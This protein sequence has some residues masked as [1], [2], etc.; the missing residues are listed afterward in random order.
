MTFQTLCHRSSASKSC[1]GTTKLV[2]CVKTAGIALLY[3]VLFMSKKFN[4]AFIK[5]ELKDFNFS[6]EILTFLSNCLTQLVMFLL[7]SS[8]VNN[9]ISL[10]KLLLNIFCTIETL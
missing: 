1:H 8:H 7:V 10:L 9:F 6:L 5:T 4:S 2:T 3:S